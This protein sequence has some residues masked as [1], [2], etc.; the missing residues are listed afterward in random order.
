MELPPYWGE[1]EERMSMYDDYASLRSEAI[2]FQAAM[3]VERAEEAR[4]RAAAAAMLAARA[5]AVAEGMTEDTIL[6]EDAVRSALLP[7]PSA[8][9]GEV[10]LAGGRIAVAI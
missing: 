2:K 6:V 5:R 8:V 1:T 10:R 9:L 4:L 3:L 7:A